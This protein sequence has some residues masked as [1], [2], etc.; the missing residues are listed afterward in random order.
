M[1]KA[2]KPRDAGSSPEEGAQL[3]RLI[4]AVEHVAQR[5]QVLCDAIDEFRTEFV[6]A[7]R[8]DLFRSPP[9][10]CPC[11]NGMADTES[12]E[13][14]QPTEGP[15]PSPATAEH[16]PAPVPPPSPATPPRQRNFFDASDGR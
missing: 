8:N 7:L 15:G 14:A 16:S 2:R 11:N 1:A 6:W 10:E 5:L 4:E 9:A 13:E 12:V 3:D